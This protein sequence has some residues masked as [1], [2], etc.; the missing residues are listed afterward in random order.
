MFGTNDGP[1]GEG[2]PSPRDPWKSGDDSEDVTR[3]EDEVLLAAVLDLGAAVL[4]VDHL[5]ADRH[6]QRHAVAVVV[7]AARTDRLDLALLGLLLGGVR[8]DQAGGGGLL[9]F[10]RLDHDAVLEGL[11]V[12]RHCRPQLS[13][14]VCVVELSLLMALSI[15]GAGTLTRRVPTPKLA[16]SSMECQRGSGEGATWTSSP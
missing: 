11:D 5:V 3:G 7:D 14:R 16:L 15:F 4:A 12:D 9:G 1:R 13:M 6:V 2:R 8:D 10:E